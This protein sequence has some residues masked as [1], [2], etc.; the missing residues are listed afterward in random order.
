MKEDEEIQDSSFE[1][2]KAYSLKNG[3]HCSPPMIR[4]MF[5]QGVWWQGEEGDAYDKAMDL[6]KDYEAT[7]QGFKMAPVSEAGR[8]D[9][10]VAFHRGIQWSK[11]RQ[12][13]QTKW[14]KFKKWIRAQKKRFL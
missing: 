4:S 8:S 14:Y 10:I 2:A 5:V 6:L 1:A 12:L 11:E 7:V 13:R 9:L 3:L